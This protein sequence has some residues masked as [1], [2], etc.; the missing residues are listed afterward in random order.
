VPR[1]ATHS[2]VFNAVAESRRRDILEYLA[3]DER[4]VGEIADALEMAQPSVSKHLNVLLTAGLV[5]VRRDGRRALYRT[6]ADALRPVYEWSSSFAQ[7]WRRQLSRIKEH[8]E[9]KSSH[10]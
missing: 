3:P 4:A 6:D 5:T 8:A 2:D 7:Y 1:A 10:R 9:R